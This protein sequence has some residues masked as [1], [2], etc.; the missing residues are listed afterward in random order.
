LCRAAGLQPAGEMCG[1]DLGKEDPGREVVFCEAGPNQAMART[2]S[3]KLIVTRKPSGENLF[4]DLQK[5]PWELHN[6]YGS[7]EVEREV[8]RLKAA[9]AGWRPQQMP[10]RFVDLQAPQIQGPN[11]PP[12]G[13]AHRQAIIEYYRGKM[14]ASSGNGR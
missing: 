6:L 10:E 3:Y 4:F 1:E 14:G 8:E 5:D 11:V 9:L 12:P 7:P 2:R 13:L